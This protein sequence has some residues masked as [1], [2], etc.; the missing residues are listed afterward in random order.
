MAQR[1]VLNIEI[2]YITAKIDI[3]L[4]NSSRTI[5]TG[6]FLLCFPKWRYSSFI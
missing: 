1:E 3:E 5:G 4:P 6:I 2:A